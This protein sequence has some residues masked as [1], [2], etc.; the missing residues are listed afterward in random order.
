MRHFIESLAGFRVMLCGV[1]GS[2][3]T[4]DCAL[5]YVAITILLFAFVR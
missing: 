5:A 1:L 4:D 2:N 3:F